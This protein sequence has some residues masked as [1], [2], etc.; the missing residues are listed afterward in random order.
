MLF[1]ETDLFAG[2]V[3]GSRPMERNEKIHRM[4]ITFY[5]FHKVVYFATKPTAVETLRK[6]PAFSLVT[7]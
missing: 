6:I 5:N 1:A 2:H 3:V 7:Q 4:T